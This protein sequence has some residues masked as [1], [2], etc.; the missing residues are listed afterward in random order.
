[1]AQSN[2]DSMLT[3]SIFNAYTESTKK[4]AA[5][6]EIKL[7]S[8]GNKDEKQNAAEPFMF[9]VSAD[10]FISGHELH[11][12]VFGPSS[13]HISAGN[14]DELMKIAEALQGQLTVTIWG[15]DKDIADY[16]ELISYL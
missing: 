16:S 8:K 10:T 15:T 2:G 4:I 12:E 7:V 6:N 5:F 3:G 11:E 1:M 9:T 14:K 13:L